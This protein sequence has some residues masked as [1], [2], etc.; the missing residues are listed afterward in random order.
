M[1]SYVRVSSAW[2]SR[3]V[4]PQSTQQIL[5]LLPLSIASRAAT[6]AV[7]HGEQR[8]ASLRF[9][10]SHRVELLGKRCGASHDEQRIRTLPSSAT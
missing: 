1:L 10:T 3:Y 4:R 6:S 7:S 2:R 5:R 9:M 8:P